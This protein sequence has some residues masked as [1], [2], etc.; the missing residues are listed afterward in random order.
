MSDKPASIVNRP[1]NAVAALALCEDTDR[2]SVQGVTL[3]DL[4][5]QLICKTLR[6]IMVEFNPRLRERLIFAWFREATSERH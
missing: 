2:R 1:K 4:G 5:H 3:G 6:S